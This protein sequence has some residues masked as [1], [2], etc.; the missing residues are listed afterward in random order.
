MKRLQ[1]SFS[2][3]KAKKI[4]KLGL[5]NEE[6]QEILGYS[7]RVMPIADKRHSSDPVAH[8]ERLFQHAWAIHNA[9]SRNWKCSSQGC[10]S[11]QANLC[12]QAETEDIRFKVLFILE[13]QHRPVKPPKKQEVI[14][15]PVK[16]GVG[17]YGQT[18][19]IG[20]VHR[21]RDFAAMQERFGL[22][23]LDQRSSNDNTLSWLRPKTMP[24]AAT[25]GR[26][27]SVPKLISRLIFQQV[28]VRLQSSLVQTKTKFFRLLLQAAMVLLR[29]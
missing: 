23:A 24:I 20:R 8:F 10:G 22:M 17:R 3:G 14:I 2:K 5:H 9:L 16:T 28:V 12:L 19:Q 21:S 15:R 1:I 7:E 27:N 29:V 26:E 13:D 11:H 25:T 6:L 18:M 4:K